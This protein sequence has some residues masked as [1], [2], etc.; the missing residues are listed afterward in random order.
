MGKQ[1]WACFRGVMEARCAYLCIAGLL[2]CCLRDHTA[3]KVSTKYGTSPVIHPTDNANN[4]SSQ[5]DASCHSDQSAEG[6]HLI[7]PNADGSD[8]TDLANQIKEKHKALWEGLQVVWLC[9]MCLLLRPHNMAQVVMMSVVEKLAGEFVLPSIRLGPTF[10]LLYCLMMGQ[11]S[12][13]FQVMF[14]FG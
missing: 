6:T 7:S 8:G 13:F 11:A 9:V 14:C 5:H 4:P 2:M 1:T 10:I 3:S 12:F